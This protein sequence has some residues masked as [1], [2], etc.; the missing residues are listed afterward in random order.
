MLEWVAILFSRSKRCWLLNVCV[1]GRGRR[2][3]DGRSM[4]KQTWEEMKE[5]NS[6]L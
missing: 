5:L 1:L 3:E 2:G 6:G 4:T